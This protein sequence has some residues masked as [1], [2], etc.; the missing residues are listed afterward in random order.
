[1][2]YSQP[3]QLK[4][5]MSDSDVLS[6]ET[7]TLLDHSSAEWALYCLLTGHEQRAH[8]HL[9]RIRPATKPR[10][11]QAARDLVALLEQEQTP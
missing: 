6:E 8:D 11:L 10:V 7:S 9:H 3:L 5:I 2:T 1:V 4:D